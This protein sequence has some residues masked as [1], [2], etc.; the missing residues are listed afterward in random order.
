MAWRGVITVWLAACVVSS[1]KYI[2]KMQSASLQIGEK[3]LSGG[4]Q[5]T[6]SKGV[7]RKASPSTGSRGP[8]SA[9]SSPTEP[10]NSRGI[11]QKRSCAT[12][13]NALNLTQSL[14]LEICDSSQCRFFAHSALSLKKRQCGI[15]QS[16]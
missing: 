1:L 5:F 7:L 2:R 14:F 13:R 11:I 4:G 6:E 9:R 16:Q 15:L 8:D 10:D 3:Q 12:R